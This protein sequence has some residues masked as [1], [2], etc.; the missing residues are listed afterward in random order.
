MPKTVDFTQLKERYIAAIKSADRE[1]MARI[2][3]QMRKLNMLNVDVVIQ[4]WKR[5][6]LAT[7]KWYV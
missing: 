2:E 6:V 4:D 7:G 3:A 5:Q 1:A